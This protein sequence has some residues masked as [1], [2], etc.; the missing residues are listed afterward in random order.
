MHGLQ[1]QH[2]DLNGAIQIKDF[3]AN[4]PITANIVG[5]VTG[6][7]SS[8]SNHDT[9][10]LTESTS[11]LYFTNARADARADVRIG[12]A[13][14]SDLN[15]VATTSPTSGQILKWNGSAWAPA[16][17]LSGAANQNPI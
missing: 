3:F 1:V 13:V 15:N 8:I 17:D 11:N 10:D 7:V 12:A 14:I 5:N 6:T 9:G 2:L 16:A 4:K